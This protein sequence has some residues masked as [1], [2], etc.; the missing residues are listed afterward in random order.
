M[1]PWPR[2]GLPEA[3]PVA[4][5]DEFL[6]DSA[7][8]TQWRAFC[9]KLGLRQA[10]PLDVIGPLFVRFLMPA[11][12]RARRQNADVMIWEPPGPWQKAERVKV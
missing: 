11:V 12:E 9:R 1:P 5:T 8:R 4:L 3:P 2:S 10:P 6:L 7:K